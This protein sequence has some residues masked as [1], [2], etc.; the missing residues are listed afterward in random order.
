[1]NPKIVGPLNV[2]QKCFGSKKNLDRILI[3]LNKL[4]VKKNFGRKKLVLK[5]EGPKKCVTYQHVYVTLRQ[6]NDAIR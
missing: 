4:L 6:L 2:G 1:M 3:W 5:N